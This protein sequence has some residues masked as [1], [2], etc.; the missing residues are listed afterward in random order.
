MKPGKVWNIAA[1]LFA[2]GVSGI[3]ALTTDGVSV[4]LDVTSDSFVTKDT[5][6]EEYTGFPVLG[7]YHTYDGTRNGEVCIFMDIEMQFIF[8][9][10]GTQGFE[11]IRVPFPDADGFELMPGNC[12]DKVQII[13]ID[14][15]G[16]WEVTFEWRIDIDDKYYCRI[17]DLH[18]YMRRLEDDPDNPCY[19]PN[20]PEDWD[21]KRRMQTLL[22]NHRHF[23]S[24]LGY[25]YEC[26]TG[27]IIYYLNDV[28][29]EDELQE[30]HTFDQRTEAFSRNKTVPA[31]FSFYEAIPCRADLPI[32]Y[33]VPIASGAVSFGIAGIVVIIYIIRRSKRPHVYESTKAD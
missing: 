32:D 13:H 7:Y 20:L 12:T 21:D 16:D 29:G 19:F 4:S 27:D 26:Y 25:A 22:D 2:A 30:L 9:Y 1:F 23:E 11:V 33:T 6:P 18:Y 28:C 5:T 17:I 8:E 3:I 15:C 31:G 14:V 10:D 24:E